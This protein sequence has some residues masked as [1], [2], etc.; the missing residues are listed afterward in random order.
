[1]LLESSCSPKHYF[2]LMFTSRC[3]DLVH[4]KNWSLSVFFVA[5]VVL[6]VQSR[7]FSTQSHLELQSKLPY[8]EIE[9]LLIQQ[10]QQQFISTT[11]DN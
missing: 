6:Q 3:R 1:M 10:R 9:L 7:S 2:F 4:V 11:V 8:Y 5:V